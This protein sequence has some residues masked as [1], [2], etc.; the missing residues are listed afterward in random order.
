VGSN[1]TPGAYDY[2]PVVPLQQIEPH[3]LSEIINFGLWMQ[4]Q[5]YRPSTTQSSI[6]TLKAIARKTSVLNPDRVKAYLATAQVSE[7]RKAKTVEDLDRFYNYKHIT[8]QKP[9]YKRIEKLPFIPL[10]SEVDQLIASC[11]RKPAALLQLIKETGMRAGEAWNLKWTDL[12]P[13]HQTINI[14]PEKNS[15]PRQPHISTQLVNML[16]AL[17]K[18]YKLIFR[19]PTVDPQTSMETFRRILA[20]QRTRTAQK[21]Q[22]PRIERIT[23]KTLR[24]FKATMEYHRTKDILHVMRLLG[25]KSIRNTLVYTHLVDFG[26]DEW[27]CKVASTKEERT[28]LIEAGFT[29]VSKQDEEWYFRRR[30]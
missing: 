22:N 9:N 7:S 30:K 24:H 14:A 21:L 3:A 10:E 8:W 20:A 11:R 16:N 1:P 23:L 2:T 28:K 13:I 17:P 6:K 15:N 25:H 4:K 27:I 12:D 29:F 19:N 18:R 5:G 26:A